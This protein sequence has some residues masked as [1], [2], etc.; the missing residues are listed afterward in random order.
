MRR[1]WVQTFLNDASSA[2]GSKRTS[3]TPEPRH[4]TITTT[5]IENYHWFM[6]KLQL[7]TMQQALK[8]FKGPKNNFAAS[9]EI[10]IHYFILWR[11]KLRVSCDL[12]LH[13]L[14]YHVMILLGDFQAHFGLI[15][16]Y[17][18]GSRFEDIIYQFEFCQ[19]HTMKALIKGKRYN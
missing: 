14:L 17:G 11:C 10:H 2:N 3:V 4:P 16:S 9:Y 5:T 1:I 7:L 13:R 12:E 8:C 19:P 18:D 15:G 6:Q